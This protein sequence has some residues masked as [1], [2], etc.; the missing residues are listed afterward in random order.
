M[1]YDDTNPETEKEEYARA[2]EEDVRWLGFTHDRV[3]DASDYFKTMYQFALELIREGK[4]Y[5]DDLTEEELCERRAQ[6]TPV[7]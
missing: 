4:A 7:P 2:I 6:G 5:V 3:L 1:R